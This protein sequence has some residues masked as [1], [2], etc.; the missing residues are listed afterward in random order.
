MHAAGFTQ[1]L[2]LQNWGWSSNSTDFVVKGAPPRREAPFSIELRYVTPGYFQALG[3]PIRAGR[4]IETSDTGSSPR[5]ILVNETL[6]R[7]SFGT[8]DPSASR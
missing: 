1:V 7:T 6:A 8:A 2:P 3:I 5:V 4:G